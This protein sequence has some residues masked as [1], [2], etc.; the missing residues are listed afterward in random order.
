MRFGKKRAKPRHHASSP[1][2]RPAEKNEERS[3]PQPRPAE[4]LT[5]GPYDIKDV[6]RDDERLDL[7]SLQIPPGHEVELR[8][9]MDQQTGRV[10][11]VTAVVGESAL[12]LIA[13]AAP[14]SSGIWK[15]V[16]EEILH[17]VLDQGGAVDE[18]E[19]TLG[20]ELL[21]GAGTPG[22]LRLVAAEG[23]RWMVRGAFNGPAATQ[24]GPERQ[25]LEAL[26][27][28]LVVVRGEDPMP[29]RE[30]LPLTLPA[31]VGPAGQTVTEDNPER[32]PLFVP[33]R[34]PETTVIG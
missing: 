23:P 5:D 4:E 11:S 26:F 30:Q 9:E 32:P 18:V 2:D 27:R 24:D 8:M 20:E 7:G 22:V 34:G 33:R 15:P 17:S 31:G 21:V 1:V 6:G 29:P 25:A 13:F 14:R 10:T 3:A 12:Q 16:R 19:G 28:S